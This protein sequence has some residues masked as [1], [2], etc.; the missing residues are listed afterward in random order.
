MSYKKAVIFDLDGTLLDTLED[1]ADS[2][3]HELARRGMRER[4]LDEVR[5]FVGDGSRKL[6]ERAVDGGAERP[7]FEEMFQEFSIY[8]RDRITAPCKCSFSGRTIFQKPAVPFKH[9][10]I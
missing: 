10:R 1:I 2:L 8:Y 7:D 6:L 4:T 5:G 9:A 3:N